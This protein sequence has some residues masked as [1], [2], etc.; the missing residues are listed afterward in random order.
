[1][2][3]TITVFLITLFAL[4]GFAKYEN[5]SK[6]NESGYPNNKILSSSLKAILIVGPQEDGTALAIESMDKIAKLFQEKG[7]TVT[8]FY[9]SKAK[10][11]DIKL[12]SPNASFLVYAGHGSTMGIGGKTGGLCLTSMIDVETMLKELKLKKNA[13]VIF[14]SVCGGAGSSASDEKDIGIKE[15]QQRV[16]DYSKPFFDIGA[17][18]YYANNYCGGCKNFLKDFLSG[19]QLQE[20][21][22]NSATT[23]SE[24]ELTKPY[25]FNKLKQISIASS[26]GSGGMTTRITY[27]NDVKKVEEIPSIKEYEIAY[28]GFPNFTIKDLMK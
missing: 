21:F 7:V 20:C 12:A 4:T 9:D 5:N 23:W 27:I 10:W 28:V 15:A 16:S 1:M 17:S 14:Q 18:A 22:T 11:E 8:K 19:L 26:R 3:R 25:E 2:K 24:I 13:M 6:S